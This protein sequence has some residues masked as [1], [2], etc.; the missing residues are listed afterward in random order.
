MLEKIMTVD[1]IEVLP[2]TK[3]VQVRQRITIY[4]TEGEDRKELSFSFHRYVLEPGVDLTD[5]PENVRAI[6][7]AAWA[8]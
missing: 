1:R 5:Q 7:E 4:E 8:T 3:H 2:E 6:A